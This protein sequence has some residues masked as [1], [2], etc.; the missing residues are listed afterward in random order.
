MLITFVLFRRWR[1][2]MNTLSL[3]LAHCEGNI[4]LTKGQWC[5]A[6]MFSL[7]CTWTNRWENTRDAGDLR[8]HRAHYDVTVMRCM[9]TCRPQ[10][11]RHVI[12]RILQDCFTGTG[13]IVW[14]TKRQGSNPNRWRHDMHPRPTSTPHPL[15]A[16]SKSP[17]CRPLLFIQTGC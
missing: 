14:F 8:R 2:Q 1:H 9:N 3:L 6:F 4:P 17:W 11:I 5:G 16:H 7:I 15:Q 10:W 12:V 13:T